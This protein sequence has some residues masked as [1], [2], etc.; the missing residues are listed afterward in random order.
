M[1]AAILADAEAKEAEASKLYA[2]LYGRPPATV[3]DEHRWR[4]DTLDRI[5]ELREEAASIRTRVESSREHIRRY[6]G[7]EV[8]VGLEVKNNGRP[9][10]VVGFSGQYIEVQLDGDDYPTT[11]HAT[12]EMEY[13]QGTRIG[14]DPDER[15]AH[16]VE[17]RS[18]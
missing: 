18:A 5:E 6:Y 4:N 10:R 16:L 1:S 17:V 12:S 2:S 8:H 3:T 13:P 9:G 14:P 15:F 11:C 7:L